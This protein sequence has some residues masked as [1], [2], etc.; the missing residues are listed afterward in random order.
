MEYLLV[1]SCLLGN[2][3]KYNG[4]NNYNPLVEKLKDKYI[5]ISCCPEVDGG[6]SIP[7]NPS[8]I[9]GELVVSNKGI[10]VTK[11]FNLGAVKA[12][13][14]VKKYNITK[15]LLKDGSPS[16]GNTYIYDGSFTGTKIKSLGIT[17]RLLSAN[18][19]LIFNENEI[20]K[21]L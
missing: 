5:L 9:K 16:C 3:T 11:E 6:L 17:A 20:E 2:N 10:D 7:R 13:E 12:L 21:L 18:G 1:S 4:K 8:E 19:V 15:A 14:L